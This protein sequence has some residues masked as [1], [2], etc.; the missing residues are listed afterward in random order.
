MK[1]KEKE[2]QQAADRLGPEHIKKFVTEAS[3]KISADECY[4]EEFITL[5]SSLTYTKNEATELFELLKDTI[6]KYKGN[7]ENFLAEFRRITSDCQ[8]LILDNKYVHNLIMLEL[9]TKCVCYL[10]R[11]NVS[12]VKEN[13][14]SSNLTEKEM[15]VLQY[16]AGHVIHK[17]FLKLRKSK[18]WRGEYFQQ[19]IQLLHSF[20]IDSNDQK[21]IKAKDRGGLWY[22]CNDGI[23]LF[24]VAEKEFLEVTA[25][26]VTKIDYQSIVQNLLKN[27]TLKALWIKMIN[28]SEVE[29]DIEVSKDLLE[30]LFGLFLRIRSHAYAKK[31]FRTTQTKD[32][33]NQT[34]FIT[35][36]IKEIR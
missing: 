30:K 25:G 23:K 14:G 20:K 6:L 1:Q 5:F 26:H 15:A 3:L 34:V 31:H 22:I 21:L 36:W 10:N 35:N 9:S 16:V 7:A 17:I 11:N 28:D 27:P 4:P 32:K 8:S 24:E 12:V 19:C 13:T 33:I 2:R 18:H 29:V